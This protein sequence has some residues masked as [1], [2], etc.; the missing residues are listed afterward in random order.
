MAQADTG[1]DGLD[2]LRADLARLVLN[3]AGQALVRNPDLALSAALVRAIERQSAMAARHSLDRI[4]SAEAMADAVLDAVGPELIRIARAAGAVDARRLDQGSDG[5]SV[6]YMVGLGV[7]IAAAILLFIAG[8]VTA[9]LL[10]DRSAVLPATAASA[11]PLNVTPATGAELPVR[12][13]SAMPSG[14]PSQ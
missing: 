2:D 5:L 7:A 4:P 3:E 13:G 10:P 6:S 14:Q 1:Q 9:R 11:A 8:F 12:P